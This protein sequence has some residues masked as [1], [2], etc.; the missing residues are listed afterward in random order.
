MTNVSLIHRLFRTSDNTES[1]CKP[2]LPNLSLSLL[3]AQSVLHCELHCDDRNLPEDNDSSQLVDCSTLVRDERCVLFVLKLQRRFLCVLR[4]MK[5][6]YYTKG[7][8]KSTQMQEQVQ[9]VNHLHRNKTSPREGR[10]SDIP[11]SL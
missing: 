2:S 8:S 6:M 11:L 4:S 1:N 9:T 10:I 7:T 3:L 5:Q